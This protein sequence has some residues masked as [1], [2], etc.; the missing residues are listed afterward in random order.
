M[1]EAFDVTP[2]AVSLSIMPQ[3]TA[4]HTLRTDGRKKNP[5]AK[6][7]VSDSVNAGFAYT[8]WHGQKCSVSMRN[9][10]NV[11]VVM[12]LVKIGAR[13]SG[14]GSWTWDGGL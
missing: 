7:H 11:Y 3:N 13:E 10:E 8:R 4:Q 14:G 9:A 12:N 5:M 1:F 6:N 2:I